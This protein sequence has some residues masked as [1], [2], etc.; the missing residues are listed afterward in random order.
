MDKLT[1]EELEIEAL[2]NEA[3]KRGAKQVLSEL[4]I[5]EQDKETIKNMIIFFKGV[6]VTKRLLVW[7]ASIFTAIAAIMWPIYLLY[8]KI[9]GV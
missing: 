6:S 1:D 7:T 4:G 8:K 5:E 3:A 2:L 9:T